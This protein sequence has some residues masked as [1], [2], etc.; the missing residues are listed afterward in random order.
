LSRIIFPAGD[1]RF[2][3]RAV[4]VLLGRR[5][6]KARAERLQQ[7]TVGRVPGQRV[8]HEPGQ[9]EPGVV[10]REQFS[11]RLRPLVLRVGEYRFDQRLLGGEV[12]VE[13]AHADSG[14]TRDLTHVDACAAFGDG[15]CRGIENGR[16]V[17]LGVASP[18]PRRCGIRGHLRR[19]YAIPEHLLRI[20]DSVPA[21]A[22]QVFRFG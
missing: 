15:L 2:D 7:A 21:I 20:S 9:R 16:A 4:H 5:R 1:D 13:G 12:P 8:F 18:S 17:V 6:G 3:R 14:R 22:E 10:E 11:G 19:C